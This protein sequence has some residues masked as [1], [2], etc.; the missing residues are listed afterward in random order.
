MNPVWEK[1]VYAPLYLQAGDLY[2][3]LGKVQEA[4]QCF[5]KGEAYRRGKYVSHL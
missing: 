3:T 5:R 4:L 2:E 1:H